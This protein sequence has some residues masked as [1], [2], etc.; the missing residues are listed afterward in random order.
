MKP[1]HITH[2]VQQDSGTQMETPKFTYT[3]KT[4]VNFLWVKKQYHLEH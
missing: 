3:K 4:E 2:L 1:G